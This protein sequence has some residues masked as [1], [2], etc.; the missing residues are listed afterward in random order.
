MSIIQKLLV[1]FQNL[2]KTWNYHQ[3][4]PWCLVSVLDL[5]P[6]WSHGEG[7]WCHYRGSAPAGLIYLLLAAFGMYLRYVWRMYILGLLPSGAGMHD[8]S[9]CSTFHKNISSLLSSLSGR[10][11]P[12]GTHPTSDVMP[13]LAGGGVCLWWEDACTNHSFSDLVDHQPLAFP[14]EWLWCYFAYLFMAYATSLG[15]RTHKAFGESQAAF[16]NST[17]YRSLYQVK[18]TRIFVIRRTAKSFRRVND[19]TFQTSSHEADNSTFAVDSPYIVN[20]LGRLLMV[21]E[22]RI[23]VSWLPL[24]ATWTC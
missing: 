12:D 4:W 9:L 16:S 15:E 13:Y 6:L 20:A 23:T 1:V 8:Y 24:S 5:I 22:G 10:G 19:P 11:Y 14:G 18:V 17:R 2:R 7:H 21:Q 3:S